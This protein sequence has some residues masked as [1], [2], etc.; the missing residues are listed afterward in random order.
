VEF[1]EVCRIAS[2]KGAQILFVPFNTDER[3]GYLRIRY[4]A[5]ARC[6]E[7]HLFVAAAGCVGNLPFVANAD[8]HYAQSGIYTPSDVEFQR[9]GVAA[10]CTPNIETVV[11]RD[12]DLEVIRRHRRGGTVRNWIDRR[13]DLYKIRYQEEGQEREI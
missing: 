12:V 10:E 5:L 4:C 7:N 11:I 1:P 3:T 6:I 8:I 9:D 2:A 13:D